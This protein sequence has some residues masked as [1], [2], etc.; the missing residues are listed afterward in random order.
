MSGEG[1]SF[2]Y[3]ASLQKP[4]GF[5]GGSINWNQGISV[6]KDGPNKAY[7]PNWHQP[8]AL[9][10]DLSFNWFEEKYFL[11]TSFQL[12]WASGMPYTPYLGYLAAHRVDAGYSGYQI[13]APL[14]NRNT[15]LQTPYFRLDTK[16]IDWGK[17]DKWNFGFTILNL[18]DHDNLFYTFYNIRRSPPESREIYQFPFFPLLINYEYYF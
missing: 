14:G 6:F 10:G 4:E 3:E 18:T 8:F 9:K 1:Y 5:V 12:K 17:K 11:R 15:T 16:L 7:F 13:I 2:G